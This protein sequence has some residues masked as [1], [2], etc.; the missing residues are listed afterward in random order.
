MLLL[1]L[2]LICVTF[3]LLYLLDKAKKTGAM[4]LYWYLFQYMYSQKYIDLKTLQKY[5]IEF[6]E[7]LR[8]KYT[9]E[10]DQFW[11][12]ATKT[13]GIDF[14]PKEDKKIIGEGKQ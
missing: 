3:Y 1:I 6:D 8:N 10:Y 11:K 12:N 2:I 9:Y 14:V 4:N 5:L 13:Y 7:F